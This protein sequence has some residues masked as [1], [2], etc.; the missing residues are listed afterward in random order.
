MRKTTKTNQAGLT[1]QRST[2]VVNDKGLGART[3]T[4]SGTNF[5]GESYKGESVAHK[6]DTGYSAQ[7]RLTKADGTTAVRDVSAKLRL[8]HEWIHFRCMSKRCY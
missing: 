3:R 6:T 5:N 4:V 1:A 8:S 7:R 2:T